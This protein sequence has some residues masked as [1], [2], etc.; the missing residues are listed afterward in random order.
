[1]AFLQFIDSQNR[2]REAASMMR[3][4]AICFRRAPAFVGWFLPQASDPHRLKSKFAGAP[5]PVSL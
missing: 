5:V 2:S 1:M 3:A 4:T